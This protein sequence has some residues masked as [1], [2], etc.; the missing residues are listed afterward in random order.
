MNRALIAVLLLL[1][2]AAWAQP[3]EEMDALVA[4]APVT[5]LDSRLFDRRLAKELEG[6]KDRIEVE[7]TSKVSLSSIP[8]R[9]DR[10]LVA[11]AEEGSVEF[12]QVEA[13]PQRTRFFLGLIP[14]VFSS[15]KALDEERMYRTSR[16]YNVIVYYKKGESGDANIEKIVFSK[17]TAH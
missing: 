6:G 5:F 14:L 16:S 7:V 15:L 2:G 17:K 12:K 9:M 11:V 13:A 3:N 1:A 10:W 4:R 8:N